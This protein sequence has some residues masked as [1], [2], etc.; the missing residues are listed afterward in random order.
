MRGEKI[1]VTQAA[2]Q[3]KKTRQNIFSSEMKKS[4]N[5]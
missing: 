4:W 3:N 5:I 1:D 2:K